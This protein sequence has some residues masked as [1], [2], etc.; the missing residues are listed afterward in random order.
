MYDNLTFIEV[1][2]NLGS[3]FGARP[4]ST[5]L[6]RNSKAAPLVFAAANDLAALEASSSVHGR[7]S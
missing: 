3:V 4:R 7:R 1:E 6:D 5:V 2:A